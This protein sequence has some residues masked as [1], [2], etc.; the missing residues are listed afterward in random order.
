MAEQLLQEINLRE[1]KA[2]EQEAT[3]NFMKQKAL[4]QEATINLMKQKADERETLILELENKNIDLM[5]ELRRRSRELRYSSRATP[6]LPR[7]SSVEL[8]DTAGISRGSNPLKRKAEKMEN[9][10]VGESSIMNRLSNVSVQTH[11]SSTA[12]ED[13]ILEL[14]V[15]TMQQ[16][17]ER[18]AMNNVR[19]FRREAQ[20]RS[21]VSKLHSETANLPEAEESTSTNAVIPKPSSVMPLRR[22]PAEE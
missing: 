9:P 12:Q 18:I 1:Q 15:D 10:E 14:P 11:T 19:R 2:L 16:M 4:E 7:Q 8:D 22:G 6:D 3:I 5:I 17:M 13:D 21:A 20:A